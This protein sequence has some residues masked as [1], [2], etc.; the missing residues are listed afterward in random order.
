MIEAPTAEDV[1]QVARSL[2]HARQTIAEI[3]GVEVDGSKG[4]LLLIQ[5]ALDSG[6]IDRESEYTLRALGMAFGQVF[7]DHEPDY[8]WWMI[9]DEYGRDP[10]VRYA[11]STLTFHPQDFLLKRIERGEEVDVVDLYDSLHSQMREI[12]AEGVDGA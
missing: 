10:A 3:V 5:R 4:D 8:D 12:V 2:L 9:S 7:V 11:Q 6:V 1:D